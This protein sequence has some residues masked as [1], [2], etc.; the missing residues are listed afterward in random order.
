MGAGFG[1]Q[2]GRKLGWKT[3]LWAADSSW[4]LNFLWMPT[5]P[6]QPGTLEEMV[7]WR[8]PEENERR[9]ERRGTGCGSGWPQRFKRTADDADSDGY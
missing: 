2:T 8:I 6:R 3:S 7:P 5:P 1:R 9:A 4:V